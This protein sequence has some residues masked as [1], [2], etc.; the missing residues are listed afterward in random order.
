MAAVVPTIVLPITVA[1]KSNVRLKGAGSARNTSQVWLSA[2]PLPLG[3]SARVAWLGASALKGCCGP[4]A[5]GLTEGSVIVRSL[6]SIVALFEEAR[7]S[8]CNTRGVPGL[9]FDGAAT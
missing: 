2:R 3:A 4:N 1:V 6:K 5:P 9:I 8:R 7:W